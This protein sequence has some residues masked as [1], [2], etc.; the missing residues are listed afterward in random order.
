MEILLLQNHGV[1]FRQ[2]HQPHIISLRN[3]VAS[4]R[5]EGPVSGRIIRS[6]E[7]N[8]GAFITGGGLE[9]DGYQN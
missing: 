1:L 5:Y 3:I 6:V 8:A 9:N 7:E 2:Q 4:K